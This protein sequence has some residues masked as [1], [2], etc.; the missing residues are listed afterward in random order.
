MPWACVICDLN[1]EQIVGT[2]YKNEL[3]KSNQADFG[4]EKVIKRKVDKLY[5][6]VASVVKIDF[7][8]LIPL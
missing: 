4:I 2:F 7:S 8:G 6:K 1:G 5:V 3:Q